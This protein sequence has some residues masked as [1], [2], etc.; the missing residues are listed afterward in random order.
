VLETKNESTRSRHRSDFAQEETGASRGVLNSMV[1]T[2]AKPTWTVCLFRPPA[3]RW[4][5]VVL[6]VVVVVVVVVVQ[7]SRV[8]SFAPDCVLDR[9]TL[10]SFPFHVRSM[11]KPTHLGGNDRPLVSMERPV[12]LDARGE[13]LIDLY[14]P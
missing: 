4:G 8:A 10:S 13:C 2:N 6:V 9:S 14:L 12:F 7:G 3:L 1:V 11:P 5:L